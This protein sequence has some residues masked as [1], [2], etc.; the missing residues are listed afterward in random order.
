MFKSGFRVL[1]TLLLLAF[2]GGCPALWTGPKAASESSPDELFRAAE[3]RFQDKEYTEAVDA[4]QRLK[5]AF[6]DFEKMPTVYVKIGDALYA[7]GEYEK[8]ISRYLQFLEL[9]PAHSYV[10]RVKYYIAMSYFNQ[11]KKTDLDNAILQRAS[12]AFKSLAADEKAGKWAEKAKEKYEGCRKKLAEKEM[13]KAHTYWSMGNYPAA[14]VAAQRVI[15]Q[16]P[17]LGYDDEAKDL[18]K[19]AKE[20]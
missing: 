12:D 10:A 8:A 16:Y 7:N 17:K 2:L 6:P 15:D 18:I 4:Y 1:M 3:K 14:L 20:K 19:R 5:S 11:I 9:Y 13:Y